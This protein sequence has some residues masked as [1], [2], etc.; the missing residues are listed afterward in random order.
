MVCLNRPLKADTHKLTSRGL[1]GVGIKLRLLDHGGCSDPE[2]ECWVCLLCA[3]AVTRAF[4]RQG[5]IGMESVAV[6]AFEVKFLPAVTPF[7]H[8]R[9][10]DG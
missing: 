8:F 1:F 2:F 6:L 9:H 10:R 7:D 4:M 5:S 3:V